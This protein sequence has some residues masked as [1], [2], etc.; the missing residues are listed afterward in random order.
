MFVGGGS[1][2]S[3]TCSFS[4]TLPQPEVK[5][6]CRVQ[7]DSG[8]PLT[9]RGS[10]SSCLLLCP[11]PDLLLLV[12]GGGSSA[13]GEGTLV[14]QRGGTPERRRAIGRATAPPLRDILGVDIIL[15][16]QSIQGEWSLHF[17]KVCRHVTTEL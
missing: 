8:G 1:G 15:N 9:S 5:W 16:R 2:L 6:R 3:H 4:A 10:S 11:S 13:G 14:L 7:S 17:P 12:R